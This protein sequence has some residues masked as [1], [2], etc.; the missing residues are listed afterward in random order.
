VFTLT[1]SQLSEHNYQR[2]RPR[3]ASDTPIACASA[4]KSVYTDCGASH[5]H[6]TPACLTPGGC[7]RSSGAY[8]T[9]VVGAS[10]NKEMTGIIGE[11]DRFEHAGA[12]LM[13]QWTVNYGWSLMTVHN[14]TTLSFVY[15]VTGTRD[16]KPPVGEWDAWQLV[17][18]ARRD[19][20]RW[21]LRSLSASQQVT[22]H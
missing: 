2:L 8:T 20:I 1:L 17:V 15:H 14:A 5:H 13:D 11:L 9:L 12:D 19:G 6:F 16:A 3:D 7:A 18:R 10:G 22:T 21:S 4:D